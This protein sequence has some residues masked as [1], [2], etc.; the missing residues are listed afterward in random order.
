MIRRLLDG[1]DPGTFA[2]LPHSS[3]G[4]WAETLGLLFGA[5]ANGGTAAVR[6]VYSSLV[7]MDEKLML[8][9]AADDTPPRTSYTIG[10]LLAASFPALKFIIACLLP[11][12]L[13]ILAGRPKEG[14]SLLVLQLTL[15]AW[16]G[17]SF[18]GFEVPRLK[19]LYLALEDTPYRIA[20]RLRKLA[21][22]M[23]IDLTQLIPTANN[24]H[25]TVH[26]GDVT[27]V[28]AWP[29]FSDHG[30][31][32]LRTTMD[33]DRPDVVIID[34]FSRILGRGDQMDQQEMT[35][36]MASLQRLALD[37][38][39]AILLVDHHRKSARTSPDADPIDDIMGSTAKAGVVDCAMGLYRR[40]NQDEATL[41][42]CGRD[43]G[44]SE[45]ALEWDPTAFCWNLKQPKAAK[46]PKAARTTFTLREQ[47]TIDA[48]VEIS[49][50]SESGGATLMQLV[51]RTGHNKGSLYSRLQSLV[52]REALETHQTARGLVYSVAHVP[53]ATVEPVGAVDP[54]DPVDRPILADDGEKTAS[55]ASTPTTAGAARGFPMKNLLFSIIDRD[56]PLKRTE[57]HPWRRILLPLPA[58]V[59]PGPAQRPRSL[60]ILA[61]YQRRR[62]LGLSRPQGRP[63][64]LR[65][66]RRRHPIPPRARPSHL[67]RG[68]RTAGDQSRE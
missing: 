8:L 25:D 40:H 55:T 36:T 65:Q 11:I 27:I 31:A 47:E 46:A 23:G 19:I 30:M 43:F 1:A 29:Y 5:H 17:T 63:P 68:V 4:P 48:V 9:M 41:K 35:L 20:D 54:V 39:A 38:Q 52:D 6:T 50:G 7:R 26:Y 14:K 2:T 57:Q 58:G 53:V 15:A 10:E 64:R 61:R 12:G 33:R 13:S 45:L 18:L 28:T 3:Y 66:R 59:L 62:A 22:G 49:A 51:A 37:H 67:P 42:L 60:Q 44:D 34:T 16:L 21:K 56:V 32:D 24:G